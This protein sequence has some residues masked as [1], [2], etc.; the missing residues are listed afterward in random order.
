MYLAVC[1]LADDIAESRFMLL[2][3]LLLVAQFPLSI[4]IFATMTMFG[5]IALL[6]GWSYGSVEIR[7]RIPALLRTIARSYVCA[8]IVVGPF[9]CYLFGFGFKQKLICPPTFYSADLLNLL[10]P[11]RVNQIGRLAIFQSISGR[12][13]NGWLAEAGSC[14]SLPLIMIAAPTRFFAGARPKA[15]FCSTV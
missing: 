2:L 15:G 7:R 5:T 1:R 14:L 13:F 10:I 11:Q 9:I 6:L 8:L 4:E 12:F 3:A